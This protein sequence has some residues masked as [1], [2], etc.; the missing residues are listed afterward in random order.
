MEINDYPAPLED[1]VWAGMC[2]ETH[3][4][5]MALSVKPILWARR[6]FPDDRNG[7]ERDFS[8]TLLER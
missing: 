8:G 5:T 7:Q 6:G 4:I 1:L 2:S 3:F